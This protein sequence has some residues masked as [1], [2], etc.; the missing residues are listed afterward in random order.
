MSLLAELHVK[1]AEC[2]VKELKARAFTVIRLILH[3][4]LRCQIFVCRKR[5]YAD[6]HSKSMCID[7]RINITALKYSQ[8]SSISYFE[9]W[10]L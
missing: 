5:V 7:N 4:Y 10:L 6:C 9:L 3:I 2:K 1:S 8:C